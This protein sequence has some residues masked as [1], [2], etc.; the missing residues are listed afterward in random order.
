MTQDTFYQQSVKPTN[1]IRLGHFIEGLGWCLA[2]ACV[3]YSI[4]AFYWR[5]F[6]GRKRARWSLLVLSIVIT[7]WTLATVSPC[8]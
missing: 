3:K 6:G 8:S 7:S 1:R 4:V 5:L 2:I